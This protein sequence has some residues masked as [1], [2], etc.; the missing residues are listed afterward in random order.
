M[1][2]L[3]TIARHMLFISQRITSSAV[4]LSVMSDEAESTVILNRHILYSLKEC[5]Q[6]TKHIRQEFILS[7]VFYKMQNK[8]ELANYSTQLRVFYPSYVTKNGWIVFCVY[9]S[10]SLENIYNSVPS[11]K[12]LFNPCQNRGLR[13]YRGPQISINK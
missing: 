5:M 12:I 4:V 2:F 8:I 13:V 10:L 11:E 7:T 9:G 6:Y 1:P 3:L